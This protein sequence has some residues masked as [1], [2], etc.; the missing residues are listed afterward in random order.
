MVGDGKEVNGMERMNIDADAPRHP[1]CEPEMWDEWQAWHRVCDALKGASAS[2]DINEEP[3]LAAAI[4][5]WGELLACLR[6]TQPA[7][8]CEEAL[9]DKIA[10]YNGRVRT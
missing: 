10:A 7:E 8:V 9:N 1:G 5:M 6:M 3:L 4:E 2:I